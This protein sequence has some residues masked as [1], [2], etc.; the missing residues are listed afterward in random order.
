MI[1]TLTSS[2][3]S[4]RLNRGKLVVIRML[5]FMMKIS[6]CLHENTNACRKGA[7]NLT[8]E[9]FCKWVS[10]SFRVEISC[11]TVCRWLHYL[12]FDMSNHQKGVFFDCKDLLEQLAKFDEMTITPSTPSPNVIDGENKYIRIYHDE[13]TFYANA[14]QTRFLNDGQSQILRQ[15]SLGSSIMVSDFIVEG[16]G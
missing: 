2:K 10:D 5:S 11:E 16:Y 9:M 13:S 3:Q 8:T 14:D 4:Y 1:L 15:K 12:G 6:N 7:P